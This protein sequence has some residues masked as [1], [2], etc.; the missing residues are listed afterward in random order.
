MRTGDSFRELRV[1]GEG[2]EGSSGHL[3]GEVRGTQSHCLQGCR[4]A[5]W[6][7]VGGL[8]RGAEVSQKGVAENVMSWIWLQEALSWGRL[9]GSGRLNF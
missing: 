3:E 7:V 6:W 8:V 9:G 2:A 5:G 1:W 4:E